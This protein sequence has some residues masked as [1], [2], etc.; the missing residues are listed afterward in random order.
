MSE[1]VK[2]EQ[3]KPV[4]EI[5]IE[6]NWRYVVIGSLL[7]VLLLVGSGFYFGKRSAQR[8]AL[9]T[10]E[11]TLKH[12][13]DSLKTA[14]A[15]TDKSKDSVKTQIVT[16]TDTIVQHERDVIKQSATIKALPF[17]LLGPDLKARLET[18]QSKPWVADTT[19]VPAK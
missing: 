17:T 9:A 4:K 15:V 1:D 14:Y 8:E 10:Y 12:T 3:K 6:L 16:Q 7:L 13:L 2:I 19:L 5:S 18:A 11:Q